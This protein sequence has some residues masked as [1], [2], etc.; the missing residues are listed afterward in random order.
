M[1]VATCIVRARD[2][3]EIEP[4]ECR[5]F[6]IAGTY[7]VNVSRATITVALPGYPAAHRQRAPLDNRSIIFNIQKTCPMH[8]RPIPFRSAIGTSG[9]SQLTAHRP[10]RDVAR[11]CALYSHCGF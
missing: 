7:A 11:S 10:P 2:N 9:V 3:V 6:G 4:V 1:R 5:P 8:A